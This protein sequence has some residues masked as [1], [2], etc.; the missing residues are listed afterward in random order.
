MY[1]KS[2]RTWLFIFYIIAVL[3]LSHI[4]GDELN[5][6]SQFWKY[7]KVVH[8]IEYFGVG[9]LLV[10]ALKIQSLSRTH[11]KFIVCFLLLFPL[12]D[13]LLQYYTPRRIPDFFDGVA[14]IIGGIVGSYMRKI[15]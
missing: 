12:V 5:W 15:L 9:F 1:I 14:D 3:Y 11:W 10:N 13:E 7:D 2:W 8:F 6:V 4:P